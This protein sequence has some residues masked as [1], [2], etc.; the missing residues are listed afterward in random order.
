MTLNLTLTTK[1]FM[2]KVKTSVKYRLS[3]PFQA[4]DRN[5]NYPKF[6]PSSP[7]GLIVFE[8]A[9]HFLALPGSFGQQSYRSQEQG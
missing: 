8:G 7:S 5:D 2:I 9:D 3:D 4:L 6:L 1:I